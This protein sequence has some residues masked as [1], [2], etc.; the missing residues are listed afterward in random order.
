MVKKE[1]LNEFRIPPE[2]DEALHQKYDNGENEEDGDEEKNAIKEGQT[3][4]GGT[5]GWGEN[6]GPI[7]IIPVIK[8]IKGAANGDQPEAEENGPLAIANTTEKPLEGVPIVV[9]DPPTTG[10]AAAV[11]SPIVRKIAKTYSS[12]MKLAI[13]VNVP[14]MSPSNDNSKVPPLDETKKAQLHGKSPLDVQYDDKL[15][16]TNGG[17]GNMNPGEIN[18]VGHVVGR[19]SP[20]KGPRP[21]WPG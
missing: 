21:V 17:G 9:V 14:A 12:K 13:Q 11:A 19:T 4:G 10:A 5:E 2:L 18:R 8:K 20:R 7:R 3:E 16:S 1:V 6:W 15:A